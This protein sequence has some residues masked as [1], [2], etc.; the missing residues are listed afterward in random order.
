MFHAAITCT[1]KTQID[2]L[3]KCIGNRQCRTGGDEERN[4]REQ[5]K[6]ALIEGKQERN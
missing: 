4:A 6:L 3:S 1:A 5:E 2:H